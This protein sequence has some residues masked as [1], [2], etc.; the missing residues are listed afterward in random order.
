MSKKFSQSNGTKEK[1]S[2][3]KILQNRAESQDLR[4]KHENHKR[5]FCELMIQDIKSFLYALPNE[6]SHHFENKYRQKISPQ[7]FYDCR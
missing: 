3:K 6:N 4:G 7:T 5:K 2:K 1:F